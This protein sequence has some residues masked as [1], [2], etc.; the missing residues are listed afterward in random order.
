MRGEIQHRG[1]SRK[2]GGLTNQ[3][4]CTPRASSLCSYSNPILRRRV[5]RRNIMVIETQG[6]HVTEVR[7]FDFPPFHVRMLTAVHCNLLIPRQTAWG[8]RTYYIAGAIANG[9]RAQT[10]LT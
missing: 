5:K 1:R 2:M 3:I 10:Y 7:A 6:G 8:M 4:A 9:G